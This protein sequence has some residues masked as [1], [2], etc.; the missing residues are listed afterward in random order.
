LFAHGNAE[1]IEYWPDMLDGLRRMGISLFLPEYRGYG[2]SAGSPSQETITRDFIQFT[3]EL[4]KRKDVDPS[5][6]IF[7]GRSIGGGAVCSLISHRRPAALILMSTFTSV[8]AMAR[9]FL[10]PGFL[11]QDPF[12][13][14]SAV[15]RLDIP[16]L[17]VHGRQD[18]L[19][20][21][22]HGQELHRAAPGSRFITYQADHN[23]CPPDWKVFFED[24]RTFLSESG[25]L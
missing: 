2:R 23:T 16:I 19:I 20:P 8:T 22:E 18:N 12:D 1:L 17:I 7:I 21:W 25:L 10:M 9:R 13:N 14:L 11:V 5:R 6:I 15:S 4:V 24:V 3:D